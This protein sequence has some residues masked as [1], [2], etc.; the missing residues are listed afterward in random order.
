MLKAGDRAPDFMLQAG[1]GEIIDTTKLRG[2]RWVIYFY[3]A[4]YTSGCTIETGQ[5]GRVLGE[6]SKRNVKV[7]G[8]SVGG[9]E[10]K[11]KFAESCG[12]PD[13][14]LLS[15]PDHQV[16]ELFGVWAP[17]EKHPEGRVGRH[18]FLISADGKVERVW[19]AVVPEGHAAAVLAAVS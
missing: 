17:T 11:T 3:P 6:F 10:D 9:V 4:D 19:E 7:F 8:C 5:F 13:L 15:D 16:A 2:Q 1:T 18:T 12:V 14:P